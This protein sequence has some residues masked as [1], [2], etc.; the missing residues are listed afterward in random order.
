MGHLFCVI[1]A[2]LRN[3]INSINGVKIF[4][5]Y[6]SLKLLQ[7]NCLFIWVYYVTKQLAHHG[8]ILTS[9]CPQLSSFV[10]CSCL[11]VMLVSSSNSG[12]IGPVLSLLE[13]VPCI[14]VNL[15]SVFLA[16]CLPM[17]LIRSAG[18]ISSSFP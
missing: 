4:F 6:H 18:D 11:I 13:A 2:H 7:N 15:L 1:V 17:Y 9:I 16:R 5:F 3:I 8:F 10:N 12:K 14:C